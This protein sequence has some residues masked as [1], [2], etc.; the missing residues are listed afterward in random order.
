MA[1]PI[2][3]RETSDITIG[4]L[5]EEFLA[6]CRAKNL[7]ATTIEWYGF[8]LGKFV[9]WCEERGILTASQLDTIDLEDFVAAEKARGISA[10]SL[11]G[12]AQILKTLCRFGYR[13]KIMTDIITGQF[14]MPKAPEVLIEI[15][16]D[17][18]LHALLGAPNVRTWNG[19]RDRAIMLMLFDTMAR[20]SEI[21]GVLDQNVNPS[22]RSIRVMGKGRKERELP[23]GN[24]ATTAAV[25]YRRLVADLRPDDAFFISQLGNGMHRHTV[26][27]IL[28][29]YGKKAGI[30]GVRCSPHTLRHTAAK[31]FIL[32][33]GDVFTLQ[34]LLGHTTLYMVR[35]YVELGSGDIRLQ[36]ERFSPG[37]SVFGR[38]RP[39]RHLQKTRRRPI[40]TITWAKKA[41]G[42]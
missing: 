29:N 5:W 20:V 8:K 23:L 13:R 2:R 16:T 28:V 42:K 34:K 11:R 36:H 27:D 3:S 31:K 35:R 9:D 26:Y 4:Q 15:F 6:R 25:R 19:I 21:T 18:Q 7:S 12:T 40:T 38:P 1:E 39:V 37:D 10:N 41:S 33:G 17:E 32:S 14:E 30:T 24:E 22:E